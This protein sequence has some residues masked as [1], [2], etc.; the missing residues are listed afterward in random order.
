MD[1]DHGTGEMEDGESA[2][3]AHGGLSVWR[4]SVDSL[5]LPT[6]FAVIRCPVGRRSQECRYTCRGTPL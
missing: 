5:P 2:S 3:A 1:L 4:P 6:Q